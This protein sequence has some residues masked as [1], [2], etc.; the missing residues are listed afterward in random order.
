M[1]TTSELYTAPYIS[2]SHASLGREVLGLEAAPDQYTF[3]SFLATAQALD[4]D[5][6]PL[7]WEAA[8]QRIG[9]GGTSKVNESPINVDTSFAFKRVR[10]DETKQRTEENIFRTL[11]NEI[12][13]LAQPRVR[14]H[15]NIVQLQGICWDISADDKPWPVLVFEKSEFGDLYNFVK[16]PVGRQMDINERLKLCLEIGTAIIT[17][18]SNSM[19]PLSIAYC[20]PSNSNRNRSWRYQTPECPHLSR[21]NWG[22]PRTSY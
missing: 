6:L 21:Q 18:H 3:L 8:S 7:T 17:M 20:I 1:A 16:M 11:I 15:P 10:D 14:E 19:Y 4:I 13:V 2:E 5:L 22:I 12:A 9:L